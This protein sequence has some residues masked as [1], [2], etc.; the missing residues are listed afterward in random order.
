[1]APHLIDPDQC[2]YSDLIYKENMNL[3]SYSW[4]KYMFYGNIFHI[5]TSILPVH[6]VQLRRIKK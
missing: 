4:E 2:I 6:P 1:V 3:I 5:S